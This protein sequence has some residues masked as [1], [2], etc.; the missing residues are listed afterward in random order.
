GSM[1]RDATVNVILTVDPNAP[2]SATTIINVATVTRNEPE[3]NLADNTVTNTT[4]I[5][6]FGILSVTPSSNFTAA[7]MNGGLFVPTNQ[8]YALTN[9][10]TAPLNWLARSAQCAAPAGLA[11][12]WPLDGNAADII[13]TNS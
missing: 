8:T 11:A 6:P 5:N 7:D 10:G 3:S 12:W 2:S 1:A 9:T 4:V 13:G